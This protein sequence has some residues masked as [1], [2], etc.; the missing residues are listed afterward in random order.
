MLKLKKY[1]KKILLTIL[2]I[3]LCISSAISIMLLGKAKNNGVVFAS[4]PEQQ[5]A[6][7]YKTTGL[8]ASNTESLST[9]VA[10]SKVELSLKMVELYTKE[11]IL[12]TI[13]D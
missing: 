12:N 13:S 7:I 3:L 6:V 11:N 10:L 4:E 8:T 2:V 9:E 5:K 1:G